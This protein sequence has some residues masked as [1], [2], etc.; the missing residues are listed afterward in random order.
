M[1]L[2]PIKTKD[3]YKTALREIEV[4]FDVPDK[5]PEADRLEV[6]VMLVEKY[7]AHHYSIPAPDPID[8]LNY[9]METRGLTR[10]ELEPYIGSRGR[11][12]EVLNR[13]R[14]LTLAMIRLLSE[15]LKLPADVLIADYEL[16]HAA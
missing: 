16:R 10:K 11:V 5:T 7:E 9:A 13:A 8:F 1:E 12:A 15:G 14:P 2:K 4:L 6:L 3:E